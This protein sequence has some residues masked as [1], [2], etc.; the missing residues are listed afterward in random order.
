ME[1]FIP[2]YPSMLDNNFVDNLWKEK[3]FYKTKKLNKSSLYPH[4]E[5]VRRFMLPQMPYNNLLLFHNVESGKTFTSI[6]IV[7]SHK[8]CK[9]RA[10]ILVR[11]RTSTDNFK[12]QIHKWLGREVKYYEIK[13]YISFA[14]KIFIENPKSKS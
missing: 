8:F 10:L 4:Q 13:K 6:T 11:G 5:I 2:S 9:G 1:E 12:D 7:E 14:N 3:K